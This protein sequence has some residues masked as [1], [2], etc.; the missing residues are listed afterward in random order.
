LNILLIGKYV[1]PKKKLLSYPNL[2]GGS[3]MQSLDKDAHNSFDIPECTSQHSQ[4]KLKLTQCCEVLID[5][6]TCLFP[7]PRPWSDIYTT[8]SIDVK[9]DKVCGSKVL[10]GGVFHKTIK[11]ISVDCDNRPHKHIKRKDMPF[12]CYV[13]FDCM[14]LDDTFKIEG[15]EVICEFSEIKKVKEHCSVKTIFVEKDII[16]ISVQSN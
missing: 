13:D 1:Y 2:I 6:R 16:K 7:P 14:S 4:R 9:I 12:S 15:Q 10:I 8:S 3:T 11:Y 5:F